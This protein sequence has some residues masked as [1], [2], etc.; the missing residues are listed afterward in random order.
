MSP[1]SW[2]AHQRVRCGSAGGSEGLDPRPGESWLGRGR[3]EWLYGGEEGKRK[4]EG[5]KVEGGEEKGCGNRK[6]E[7]GKRKREE[8]GRGR[9]REGDRRK[10]TKEGERGE[11]EEKRGRGRKR[12][13][14]GGT[15]G[16]KDKKGGEASDSFIKD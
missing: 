1:Q 6:E 10:R 9:G 14:D 2:V 5:Q 15:E 13:E 4:R 16:K 8:R 12:R 11:R 3:K 7:E